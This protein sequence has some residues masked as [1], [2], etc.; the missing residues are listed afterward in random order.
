MSD[1]LDIMQYEFLDREGVLKLAKG[2]LNITNTRIAERITTEVSA[3]SDELHVPS[4]AAVYRAIINSKH[5]TVRVVTGNI[6]EQVPLA[7]RNSTTIYWQR[8]SIE[9]TKWQIYIWVTNTPPDLDGEWI[10]LGDT[11]VDLSNYW[12]K[13]DAD[14]SSLKYV[15]GVNDL[16]AAVATKASQ[17]AL[18]ELAATVDG[19]SVE[20]ATKAA[21][22]DLEA[23]STYVDTLPTFTDLDTKVA[24]EDLDGIP[25]STVQDILDEAYAD[26]DILGTKHKLTV[27]FL[28]P[29]ARTPI[30]EAYISEMGKGVK[31]NVIPPTFVDY[32]ATVD[33]VKGTMDDVDITTNVLYDVIGDPDDPRQFISVAYVV[34]EG[35]TAPA[36]V[37]ELVAVGSEYNIVSPVIEGLEPDI[38]AVTGTAGDDK[39]I[40]TVTYAPIVDDSSDATLEAGADEVDPGD[41]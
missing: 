13:S 14:V 37:I 25:L 17:D 39:V 24:K 36:T 32:Y 2:I 22:A 15:L 16:A 34:P 35:F 9:D 6:N 31:Y 11:D 20:L 33:A 29:D 41:I 19:I 4:A 21:Q 7:E 8:D 1:T 12:S 3:G 10:N 27:N 28:Y 5:M 40:A 38:A 26:T 23:L 18:N 30:A